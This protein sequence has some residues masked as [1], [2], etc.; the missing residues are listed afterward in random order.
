MGPHTFNFGDAAELA[1]DAGAARRVATMQEGVAA[2]VAWTRD[3]GGRLQACRAGEEFAS[4]HRGA[5]A[6][7]AESVLA[8]LTRPT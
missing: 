8:L 2:A 5:A 4:A 7:T 3:V 1:L 6:K